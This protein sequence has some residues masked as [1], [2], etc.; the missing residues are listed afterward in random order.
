MAQFHTVSELKDGISAILGGTTANNVSDL[1]R[2]LERAAATVLQRADIP[3]ASGQ[4]NYMFYNGVF[5]YP[6][7]PTI[8]GGALIDIQPQGVTR[9][10]NDYVYKQPI[11]QFDRTK[12]FLPNGVAVTFEHYLGQ[13]IMRI[14]QVRAPMRMIL[15]PMNDTTGWVAS[16]TATGLTT[17][18]TVYYQSPASLRFNVAAGTG[19]LTKTIGSIDLSSYEGVAVGFL[20]IY[21]PSATNLSSLS[22]KIGSS[23]V[24]Y[25]AITETEGFLGAWVANDWLLV[26]FDLAIGTNTGTPDFSNITYVQVNTV[27][28][29]T[30]TN[31]RVG[32]LWLSLPTPYTVLYQSDAIFLSE[33]V[34]SERINSDDD[35]IILNDAAYTLY[36]Y[37]CAYAIAL[38]QTT[39]GMEPVLGSIGGIL[40]G[41]RA[42]N[43]AVISLGLYDKYRAD[44]PSEQIRQIGS[45]YDSN[46]RN[47]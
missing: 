8:F 36:E 13:G 10:P 22:I 46:D 35:E 42:R 32:G 28:A 41:A 29:D 27:A 47:Y 44:N 33:G 14:A 17:D 25:T 30:L 11:E 34:L 15:D 40:N 21:T 16:G 37:E 1:Y 18:T 24:N 19:T 20:A 43:G 31:M 7:P 39:P 26:A 38:Q 5:N 45:Y 4:S 23:S 6:A 9:S 12:C 2:A 3:E